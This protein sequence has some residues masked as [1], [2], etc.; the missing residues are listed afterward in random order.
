M[1]PNDPENLALGS[2]KPFLVNHVLG[3]ADYW[4]EQLKIGDGE[5]AYL[6]G[7]VYKVDN[8]RD[9]GNFI[10]LFE[11]T[12]MLDGE[13]LLSDPR[14]AFVITENEMSKHYQPHFKTHDPTG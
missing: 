6:R 3:S 4:A 5:Y 13:W 14:G 7:N 11:R 12:I 8:S 9:R 1:N 10:V 2:K